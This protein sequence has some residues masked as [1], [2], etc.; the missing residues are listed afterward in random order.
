MTSLLIFAAIA[1]RNPFWPL[2]YDG[3]REVISP[4]PIVDVSATAETDGDQDET[5]TAGAVAAISKTITSKHW[6]EA[7][8]SLKI[9]GRSVV[10]R[11][12]GTKRQSVM[13]NGLVYANGDLIS[14]NCGSRRFTW[15][16]KGLTDGET[17]KLV[18]V[19]AKVVSGNE[20]STG[21]PK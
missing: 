18:R 1:V 10:T 21:E 9:G 5:A 12:D 14:T 2:G 3:P 6:A 20:T 7:R 11:P 13:I 19:R 8:K 4:E 17:L 15:R 16:I